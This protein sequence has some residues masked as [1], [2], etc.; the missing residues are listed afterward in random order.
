MI[1]FR[2]NK[3]EILPSIFF[4]AKYFQALET[5]AKILGTECIDSKIHSNCNIVI[6][7]DFRSVIC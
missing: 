6:N 1:E 5:F 4:S 7:I 2:R 3:R